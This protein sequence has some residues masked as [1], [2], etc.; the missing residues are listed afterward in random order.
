MTEIRYD[1]LGRRIPEYDR[2]AAAAKAQKTREERHGSDFNNRIAAAGGRKRTRGYFGH[3][4]DTNPKALREIT[5]AAGK[6]S[7][8]TRRENRDS[9]H[10]NK[11]EK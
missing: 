2:K 1:R 9:V 8:K 3:L 7:G 5:S 6:A 11:K 10:N 4:A